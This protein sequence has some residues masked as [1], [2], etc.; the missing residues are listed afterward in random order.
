MASYDKLN[1][2]MITLK[3]FFEIYIHWGA[4]H[5]QSL[6]DLSGL[7]LSDLLSTSSENIRLGL[8]LWHLPQVGMLKNE[9][10]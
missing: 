8:F 1:F 5:L 4:S 3:F 2:A 9:T 6:P 10:S 7:D